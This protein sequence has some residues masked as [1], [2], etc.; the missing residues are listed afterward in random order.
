LDSEREQVKLATDTVRGIAEDGQADVGFDYVWLD[1]VTYQDWSRY[2]DLIRSKFYVSLHN[3]FHSTM[4]FPRVSK[5]HSLGL[6]Y[7]EWVPPF[8]TH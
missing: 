2:H 5:L 4:F 8:A 1:D 6:F 7:P 3:T